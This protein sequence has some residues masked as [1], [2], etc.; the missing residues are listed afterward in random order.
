MQRLTR[1]PGRQSGLG[2]QEASGYDAADACQSPPYRELRE[3]EHDAPAAK[4]AT[5]A[6]VNRTRRL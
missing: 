2:F 3:H 4:L 5:G 6:C 1:A